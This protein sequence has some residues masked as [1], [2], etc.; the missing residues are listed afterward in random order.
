MSFNDYDYTRDAIIKQLGLIELH[1]KDGS[2]VD[3]GC[4][5]INTKH[6]YMLEGLSEEMVGFAKTEAEKKFYMQLAENMRN[7][8][9]Q[10]DAEEWG[11]GHLTK[12]EKQIYK[13]VQSGKTLKECETLCLK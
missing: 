3:A 9:R 2:A 13:C 1:G 8:R 11:S 10:I 5:C 4:Q 7:T 12:C 6:T